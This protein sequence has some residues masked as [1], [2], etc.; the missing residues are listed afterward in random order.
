MQAICNNYDLKVENF[1]SL[2]DGK[3]MWCLLDYYFRKQHCDASF[4]KVSILSLF[5]SCF[6]S[7]LQFSMIKLFTVTMFVSF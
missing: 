5:K 7:S 6:V 4:D 1:A 2:V 3:A